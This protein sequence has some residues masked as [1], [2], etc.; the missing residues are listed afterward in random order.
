MQRQ[1]WGT[2][3]SFLELQRLVVIFKANLNVI[4]L[5]N[6]RVLLLC[7]SFC[8]SHLG[9][10]VSR[11]LSPEL[12][13][14]TKITPHLDFSKLVIIIKC[15]QPVARTYV[16]AWPSSLRFPLCF[17]F[18]TA[19]ST[20][21]RGLLLLKKIFTYGS[22]PNTWK[23]LQPWKGKTRC[24]VALESQMSFQVNK[25]FLSLL[26]GQTKALERA[27]PRARRDKIQTQDEI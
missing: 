10:P 7:C 8:S 20:S 2:F 4:V 1:L 18:H 19:D 26:L 21:G 12:G 14:T 9:T 27:I 13:T 11:P 6:T 16:S 15:F 3:C 5:H 22:T 17:C 24:W 25:Y 23:Y